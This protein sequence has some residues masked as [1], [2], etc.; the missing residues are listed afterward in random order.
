MVEEHKGS[1]AEIMESDP[2]GRYQR[3]GSSLIYASRTISHPPAL[4]D[5]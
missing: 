3:V 4:S 1:D 2:Q 5:A